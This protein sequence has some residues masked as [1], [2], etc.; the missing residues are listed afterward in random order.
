MD[1]GTDRM[2]TGTAK[3]ELAKVS[4]K[5]A[6]VVFASGQ[7]IVL[8]GKNCVIESTISIGSGEA[9]VYKATIDGKPY[10][11]KIYKPNMPLSDTAKKVIS[12]IKDKPRDRIIKIYDF[13]RYDGQDFEVMEYAEG[14]TLEQYLK[15][16]GAIHDTAKL[17]SIVKM[18]AEG[19]QQLHGY[20]KVI[21]QDLKPENI[22]FKDA[23]K[24]SLV[25]ADFG[26]SSVMKG[27][28]EEVEVIANVTDL[29]A[30]P[31]LAHK[32][33]RN[34]VMVT[35]A[36]DYF[37]L[38]ITMIE[39]WLGEKPFK[40]VKATTLD[41]L[42]AEEKADL[43]V[44]MPGDY[45]T[46]IQGLI[47]PQRK[48]RWGNEHVRKWLKGEALTIKSRASKKAS[49]AYKPLKFSASEYAS[50]P[51]ELAALMEKF[52]DIGISFLYDDFITDWL[53]KAGDV[54]LFNKI[55]NITSQYAKD[56]EAGL[57]SVILALDPE[58]PFRSRGGKI[59]KT[60]EDIADAI[61]AESAYYMD[62]LKKPN[63][64]LYLYLAATESQQGKEAA[65]VFCKYFKEY[66]P[67]KALALVYLK[68]QGDGGI[69]IGKKR[70]QS[71]E[72]LKKE[73]N[74][75]QID[76]IKKAVT[77]KDSTLLVW[78]SDIYGD[79]LKSTDA[80]NNLSI[81]EQFFL[82]GLL[83][84]LSFK[85]LKGNNLV[86]QD[87]IDS[88]P[89][90]TDFFQTYAAQGLPLTGQDCGDNRTPI[91]Y[92]VWNFAF[93]SEKHGAD[94]IRNMIRLLCKLGADINEHSGNDTYPLINAYDTGNDNL[95]KL[96]LELGADASQYH[97]TIKQRVE[98]ERIK[99]ERREEQERIERERIAEDKRKRE[100]SI[101]VLAEVRKRIAKFQ[102][103]IS[104]GS[105]HTVGLKT[106]GT[107]VVVGEND[108]G[109]CNTGSWRDITAIA[110]CCYYSYSCHTVGLK[111]DGTVVAVGNNG[112][113]QCDTESWRDI[114]AIAAGEYH[115][116]G[117]KADGTVV[118]VGNNLYDQCNT[119]SWQ[120]IVAITAFNHT[121]GL[122][123]D[124]TVVAIGNDKQG[125]YNTGRDGLCNTRS[126][127]DIVAIA[128]E[129]NHTV[130]LK[131]DGTVVAVGRN[132]ESQCNTGSWRDI[133]AVAAGG[134]HTVGLKVD[135]TV[136]AVGYNE[137]GQCNT[138]SW[139]DII[140]VAAGGAHT[141]GLKADGTVVAVG[142]NEFAQCNTESWRDI[143][144]VAV[145]TVRTVGLKTDGTVV[146][147]GRNDKGQC[148]T[149][150]W[151]NIGPVPEE[152]RKEQQSKRWQEQGLCKYCGGKLGGVFSKKCKACGREN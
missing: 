22:Y 120:D 147:V 24:S 63:S 64:N 103:C 107:V 105:T 1:G 139:R 49:A 121:V 11:L 128:A 81:P 138:G 37:A 98:E 72:E 132:D 14:G 110:A 17:K 113:G 16:N 100:E 133:I 82:L 144:A 95:V 23:G 12:K 67:K 33:N 148:N 75:A 19:L 96:L 66:S 7:A 104:V 87:L 46:L 94:T 28:N 115:T 74:S 34:E 18:I 85:E 83:P 27:G 86:L 20:Y 35:P 57:Y 41:Y 36:V 127:R 129:N 65:D 76:P 45:A 26:I 2:D 56:K 142:N 151:R 124:G 47:K 29:Y 50:N 101:P 145:G 134:I 141:V 79:N 52:P 97:K 80:F 51:K 32:G 146:A 40:G 89:A 91:D 114:V 38:G 70:Y 123:A 21:Y 143:I 39:L 152:K 93:L 117:L 54:M 131:A 106:D 60:T 53:K 25:L 111:A 6:G 78:L 10:A 112:G 13:G 30:A 55:Q 42:I 150:S 119:G 99:H 31:E 102:N 71:P 122:K 73:K 4:P 58:R 126:W 84:F 136:V 135:G 116:V 61:M 59:C 69:T 43:P 109:Q 48:D 15:S 44:D 3:M 68:L 88:Y 118:A 130:G 140:A 92:A 5:K 77:E 108:S 62:D 90:R 9:V 137:S 125:Q 8:N 149:E